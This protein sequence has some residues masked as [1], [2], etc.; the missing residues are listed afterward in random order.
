[1]HSMWLHYDNC[2][3]NVNMSF[4]IL[5]SPILPLSARAE[6]PYIQIPQCKSQPES[7]T[8]GTTPKSCQ[9]NVTED[10]DSFELQCSVIRAK[11]QVNILWQEGSQNLTASQMV[12]RR[13]DGAFDV[14]ATISRRTNQ[15]SNVNFRCIAS[16]LA[17]NGTAERTVIVQI[18]K[19]VQGK[20]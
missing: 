9:Y 13:S 14:T 15:S 20:C 16:G 5:C 8:N 1:M 6:K 10:K 3:Y 17:V 19:P 4:N 12:T 11:P 2:L 7:V 18:I